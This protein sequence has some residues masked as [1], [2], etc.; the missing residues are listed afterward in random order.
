M[1]SGSRS[2]ER[3]HHNPQRM[4][5][6]GQDGELRN[7]GGDGGIA[8]HRRTLQ[9]GRDLLE[10]FQPFSAH[11]IFE[12]GKSGGVASRPRQACDE[13][14]ADG[15]ADTHEHD[16]HLA[17]RLQQRRQRRGPIDH[18]GIRRQRDQLGRAPAQE[19]A[20]ARTDAVLDPDVAPHDPSQLLQTLMKGCHASLPFRIV[21]GPRAEHP[22]AAHAL[23]LLRPRRERPRSCCA[24]Q[25]EYEFSS[26]DVDCHATLPPEVVCMQ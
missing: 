6:R 10:Q 24:A 19:F 9:P 2:V 5:C 14:G 7:A 3:A 1:P 12:Q 22:D 18:D 8:Q 17:R 26:S 13:A 4:R 25:C 16:G 23:A 11:A 15:I 20:V 21:R